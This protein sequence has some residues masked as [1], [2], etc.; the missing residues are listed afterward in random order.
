MLFLEKLS[1]DELILKGIN[2]AFIQ[3]GVTCLVLELHGT[4]ISVTSI[5]AQLT[6]VL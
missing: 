6:Y 3:C 2:F 1:L 5:H 4:V